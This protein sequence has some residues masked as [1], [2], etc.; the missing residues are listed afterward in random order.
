MGQA[1]LRNK[2]IKAV[3]TADATTDGTLCGR[4]SIRPGCRTSA[5]RGGQGSGLF[6]LPAAGS[7][8]LPENGVPIQEN[9]PLARSLYASV[10]VNDMI[11]V[12]MFIAVAEV[13]AYVFKRNKGRHRNPHIRR[14]AGLRSQRGDA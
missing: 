4:H 12:E 11:S 5:A 6:C 7:G 2:M 3:K 1:I 10:E 9:K 8:G 13:L 14:I